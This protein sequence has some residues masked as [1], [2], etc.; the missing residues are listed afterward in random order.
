MIIGG[1]TYEAD[2][3]PL[4]G[5][6]LSFIISK[7]VYR[8]INLPVLVLTSYG[9]GPVAGKKIIEELKMNGFRLVG[10]IEVS[11]QPTREEERIKQEIEKL[12]P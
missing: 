8:A 4:L 11:G 12:V 3:Q 9:W 2:I 6:I 10:N 5:Y 1:G 7:L